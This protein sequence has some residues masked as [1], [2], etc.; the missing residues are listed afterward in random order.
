MTTREGDM[1]DGIDTDSTEWPVCPACGH[2]HD[3]AGDWH[4]LEDY[5]PE[6]AECSSCCRRFRV[7]SYTT[8]VYSTEAVG[9][10]ERS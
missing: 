5:Q 4:D 8:R 3:S 10:E 2:V 6:I 1:Q 7:R 9:P